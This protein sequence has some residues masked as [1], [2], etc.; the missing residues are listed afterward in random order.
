VAAPSGGWSCTF[1]DE[2]DGTSLDPTKWMPQLTANSG[3]MTGSP[4]SYVCYVNTPQAISVSGGTLDLSVVQTP[5][6]AC[7]GVVGLLGPTMFDGGEVMSYKL[8]SQQYGYFEAR[9]QLPASTSP[10]LQETFWLYPEDLTKY[11]KWPDSGEIDWAEFYSSLP[12]NDVPAIHYPGSKNDPNAT[13]DKCAIA[14]ESTAGQWHTYGVLWTPTTITSYYDG[15]PCLTDTYAPYVTSP[16]S[17][18]QPFDQPFFLAFTAAL[19]EETDMYTPG[20]TQ[21]PATTKIDYVRVW[22]YPGT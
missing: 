6:S 4:G 8:F 7:M 12:D 5:P 20:V 10:G 2:F 19:G 16:D 17:P 13:N 9:A 3:F 21:L 1:D 14:G 11:G 18:P 22:Q 15:Q